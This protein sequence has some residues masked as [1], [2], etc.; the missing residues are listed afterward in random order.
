MLRSA[1]DEEEGLLTTAYTLEY[2]QKSLAALQKRLGP[3]SRNDT[4]IGHNRVE[5]HITMP[6]LEE[7]NLEDV[8]IQFLSTY[9]THSTWRQTVSLANDYG[10]TL[11][12]ISVVF[13]FLRLLQHL[14]AW[15]ID[16]QVQDD[17]GLTALHYAYFFQQEESV[18]FLL[19]SGAT[20]FVLDHLG[21]TP[22]D[23]GP[24]LDGKLALD[25]PDPC[26]DDHSDICSSHRAQAT[27]C[28][29]DMPDEVEML[30]AKSL[31]F[32]RWILQA[33]GDH[34]RESVSSR[35][36]PY[37]LSKDTEPKNASPTRD[38]LFPQGKVP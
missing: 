34:Y 1:F 9:S 29:L 36:E 16:L 2:L 38:S 24:Q 32:K 8:S 11:A 15:G 25:S 22:S 35:R 19:R 30:N 23:L 5:G 27:D 10:Q 3:T 6:R 14:V 17:M 18:V 37:D 31:L 7:V 13:G 12:H 21:R 33:E 4:L 20:R 26:I 28:D